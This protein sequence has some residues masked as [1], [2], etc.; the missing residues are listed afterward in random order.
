MYKIFQLLDLVRDIDGNW[1]ECG[2]F[3]GSTAFLLG[4]YNKKHKVLKNKDK[5]FLFDSFE[6]LSKPTKNDSGTFMRE[7]NYQCSEEKVRKN[8]EQFSF[9]IFKKGWI[10]YC[11]KGL[12]DKKFSFVH[13]DV[14]FYEPI[15]ESLQFFKDKMKK[16]GVIVMDDY[17]F[18]GTPGATLA[19]D[20]FVK[21]NH[22]NFYF[23]K[24]P[25]GQAVF[26]K[27]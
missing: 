9:F 12:N 7:N 24:L 10:P 14:D 18:N 5:I 16:G 22:E 27:K 19:T 13:I 3:K 26:I 20:S 1:A 11:F 25:Y 15:K 4:C 6:G 23:W 2:V 21:K 8:L 17:G